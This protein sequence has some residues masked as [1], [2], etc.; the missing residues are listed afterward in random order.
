VAAGRC[1]RELEIARRVGRFEEEGWRVRK[2]GTRYWANVVLTAIHDKTGELIGYAKVTRDLTERRRLDDERLQRVRAEEALRVRD[3]FLSIASHELKT[4]LTSLQ[5]E[6][7]AMRER[8]DEAAADQRLSRK[9]DRASRNADRLSGLID[10]LLDVSRIATGRLTL[11]PEHFDLVECVGL[12]I[13]GMRSTATRAGCDLR[14]ECP[15]DGVAIRG[16]W[17]RLR[18]EQVV[19]NLLSNAFKYGAGQPVT[20]SVSAQGRE[21]VLKVCDKGPGVADKDVH[22]IFDRFERASPMRHY[23]GLGL[24][25]YVSREIV[26]AEHG[27]IGV[28]NLPEGGACFEVHLPIDPPSSAQTPEPGVRQA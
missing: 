15:A 11:K 21:V 3:E 2:D 7:Y 23:G 10:T 27:S 14:L 12:V 26:R 20:V 4:P 6:L 8:L 19:M 9:L 24:G 1:E 17:D 16:T 25:L 22:R 13:D 5:I 28:R 18:L